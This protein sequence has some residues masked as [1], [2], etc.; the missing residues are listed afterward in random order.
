MLSEK[1]DQIANEDKVNNFKSNPSLIE[2]FKN[3]HSLTLK[4]ICGVEYELP[5][6]R[7][8]VSNNLITGNYIKFF[9]LSNM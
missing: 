4:T 6:Y 7:K 1:A 8:L 3:R 2:R 5:V 9:C